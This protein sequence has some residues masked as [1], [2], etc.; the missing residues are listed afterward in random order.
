MRTE[1]GLTLFDPE[2]GVKKYFG[3][4]PNDPNSLGPYNITHFLEDSQGYLWLGTLGELMRFDPTAG[5]FFII[6]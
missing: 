5:T 4:D 3:H 6:P 2:V 1:L